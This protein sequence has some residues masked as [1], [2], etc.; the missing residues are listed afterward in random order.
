LA[1]IQQQKLK[2]FSRLRPTQSL[3]SIRSPIRW[4]AFSSGWV[5]WLIRNWLALISHNLS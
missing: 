2:L 1:K 5:W 4:A 3:R